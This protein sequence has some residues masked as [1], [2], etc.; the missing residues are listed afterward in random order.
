MD[1]IFITGGSGLLG[2]NI[3]K[4]ALSK[5]DVY[6]SFN[7]NQVGIKGVHFLQ[8]DLAEREQLIKIK[9]IKPHFIIHCAALA[10]IDYC[11]EHPGQAY[12]QNVLGSINIA[13]AAKEMGAYLIHISTDNVFDGTKGNCKEEDITNPINVYGRTKLEAEQKISSICAHS[14]IVRTNIYGWNKR[15]KFSLA[16][17]MLNKLTALEE[18]P[19]LKDIY[20]SPILVNDLIKA[21]FK[22]Q[23]KK[24]RGIIHIAASETCSK[25][26]FA[27]ML[28]D[29]FALNKNLI[30]PVSI[31]EIEL[32]APRGKNMS[33]NAAKAQEVLEMSFSKVKEGLERMKQLRE[34]G[35]VQELKCG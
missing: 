28:A 6:A 8:M 32:K 2:S 19:G 18:L 30:K 35:Y 22:L 3:A 14:C 31:H 29:V 20:F 24:Y 10:D 34:E 17:W 25:L 16:E 15:N 1:K 5:F 33:L 13:E 4:E 23:E 27:Y 11:E 9:R 26:D 12:R 7:K 21:L